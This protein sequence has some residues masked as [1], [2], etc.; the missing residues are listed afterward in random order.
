MEVNSKISNLLYDKKVIYNL[1][2][3]TLQLFRERLWEKVQ[4]TIPKGIERRS[5]TSRYH[6]SKIS[7]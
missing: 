2:Y 4:A 6:G 7:G 5:V 1:D 3:V